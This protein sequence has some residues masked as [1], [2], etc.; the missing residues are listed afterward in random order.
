MPKNV[1]VDLDLNLTSSLLNALI[2]KVTTAQRSTLAGTLTTT[3]NIVVFDTDLSKFFGWN[4][5]SWV[6]LSQIVSNPM[7]IKGEIDASTNP[8]Y[9]SSPSIGDVWV[10]TVAGTVGGQTVQVGDQLVYSSSGWFILQA[11]LVAATT[12]IAGYVRLATQGEVDGESNSTAAVTPDKLGVYLNTNKPRPRIYRATVAS[13][14]ANTPTTVTHSLAL[15]N[16]DDYII[17][18]KDSSSNELLVSN[19]SVDVNS[20]T[21]ESNVALTNARVVVVGL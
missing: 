4:G 2:Q 18:V 11:N 3:Q 10:I 6:D 1:Y 7:T 8:A 16:K 12:A 9:P 5:T 19:L 13:V 20:L 14:P 17:S 21:I 15:G